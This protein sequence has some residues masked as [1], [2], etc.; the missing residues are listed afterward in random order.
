MPVAG[1]GTGSSGVDV[2]SNK[3]KNKCD[4]GDK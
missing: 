4:S 3:I 2:Q 1:R